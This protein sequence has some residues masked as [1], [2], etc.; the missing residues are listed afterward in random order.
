MS[1]FPALIMS[2]V[3]PNV[4]ELHAILMSLTISKT[5]KAFARL[6]VKDHLSLSEL[7]LI[8]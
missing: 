6:E 4:S 2:N 1:E 8:V 3:L 5:I 7:W